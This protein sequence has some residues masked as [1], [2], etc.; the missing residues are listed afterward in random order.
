MS[1]STTTVDVDPRIATAL[2]KLNGGFAADSTS[3]GGVLRLI[4]E[5]AAEGPGEIAEGVDPLEDSLPELR[6]LANRIDAIVSALEAESK[7]QD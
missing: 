3:L 5:R 2:G 4:L 6:E 7:P 1:S